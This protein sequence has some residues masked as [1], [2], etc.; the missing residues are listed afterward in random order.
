MWATMD[1]VVLIPDSQR[2]NA[3]ITTDPSEQV[4]S[5]SSAG[6]ESHSPILHT[7]MCLSITSALVSSIPYELGLLRGFLG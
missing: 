4:L 1:A 2:T 7:G 3:G 5:G 6:S